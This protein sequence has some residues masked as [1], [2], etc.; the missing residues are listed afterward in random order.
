MTVYLV[1][2][3]TETQM[4]PVLMG[5]YRLEADAN[6]AIERLNTLEP[7]YG[8]SFVTNPYEVQ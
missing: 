1:W 5:I 3:I 2:G 7:S 6:A 4:N 8:Y